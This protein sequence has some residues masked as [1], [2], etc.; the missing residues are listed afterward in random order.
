[1]NDTKQRPLIGAITAYP[2]S[3]YQKRFLD[4]LCRACSLYGYDVAVFTMLVQS[5]H[6][7]K[8]YLEGELNIYELINFDM[9]DG[10]IVDSISL[11]EDNDYTLIHDIE[12]KLKAKC[13]VP[14]VTVNLPMND[15]P[16][17]YTDDGCGIGLIAKHL[18]D[19][20]G[21]KPENMIFLT[22]PEDHKTAQRRLAGLKEMLSKRWYY[23]KEDQIVYGDF[24]YTSGTALAQRIV[25]N[26]IKRPRAVICASDHMAMG[27]IKELMKNGIRVPEDI[28]VTG[29]DGT[30]EAALFDPSVSSFTPETEATVHE[31]VNMLVQMIE[32][33]R[34]LIQPVHAPEKNL[35][36]CASC[37]CPENTHYFKHRFNEAL[38]RA[39][40]DFS[41]PNYLDK[42]D[43][44]TVFAS[45]DFERYTGTEDTRSCIR[46]IYGSDWLL[47]PY[48]NF[49]MVLRKDWL[50]TSVKCLKG[51]PSKMD[52]VIHTVP[53]PAFVLDDPRQHYSLSHDHM[54]PT[55]RMLP[56]LTEPHEP[57]VF[58]FVP[59]HFS[60]ETFGYAVLECDIDQEKKPGL[61]FHYWIRN[62]D[63]AL[64]LIRS[65]NKLRNTAMI[66]KMTSLSNR[67]GMEDYLSAL[68][69]MPDSTDLIA[70]V[71]DMDGLKYI[72]DH[73]GHE[74][75]D[76]AITAVARIAKASSLPTECCIRAG[77]D[78]FYIIGFGHYTEEELEDRIKEF[79]EL[80]G[81]KSELMGR[82]YTLSASAGYAIGKVTDDIDDIIARADKK[83]YAIKSEKKM[84]RRS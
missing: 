18:I 83:M 38:F 20:H 31:A 62:V 57:A 43:V 76:E 60:R 30:S 13:K 19:N 15:Y 84:A 22:G 12:A 8:D 65:R 59:I 46:E 39:A 67:R 80:I 10:V 2:E 55:S 40:T 61:I 11:T 71:I 82:P 78:E 36:L 6:F 79:H 49:Y 9:L 74:L 21:I 72:N 47:R 51:Y 16:C 1:M 5:C 77:G 25:K 44:A 14:V 26:E 54:F 58:Y 23:L 32:P 28:I 41:D 73:F 75:G 50:D 68:T 7:Y 70:I 35:V 24:W 64:E 42:I 27:V 37:G 29:Y 56:A 33:D 45:Y 48:R 34:E 81:L 69:A 66:D 3:E 63:N 17:A 52:V 4:G 53:T